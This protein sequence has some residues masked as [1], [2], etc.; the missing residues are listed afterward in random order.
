MS[1]LYILILNNKFS[2]FKCE[3]T[4][5][6]TRFNIEECES[7]AGQ[8]LL[9]SLKKEVMKTT[10]KSIQ[11]RRKDYKELAQLCQSF[12]GIRFENSDDEPLL[13]RPGAMTH[14]R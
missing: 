6:P 10:Q 5:S 2:Q 13:R 12:L 4:L 3:N 11:F 14:A 9:V 1:L 8:E 7:P